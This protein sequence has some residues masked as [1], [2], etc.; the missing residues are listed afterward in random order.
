MGGVGGGG[1]LIIIIHGRSRMT[2]DTRIPTKCR[3]GARRVFTDQADFCLHLAR[4]AV[5]CPVSHTK[6]E[7]HPTKSR[8]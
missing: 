6:G 7:L 4:S 1:V 8:F 2:I 5:R 3:D